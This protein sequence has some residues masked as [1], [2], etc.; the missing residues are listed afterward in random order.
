VDIAGA[1]A[2]GIDAALVLTGGV[3]AEQAVAAN[4]PPRHVASS[5]AA[6]VLGA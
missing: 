4:P 1:H 6:L 2:A 3:T 5:L